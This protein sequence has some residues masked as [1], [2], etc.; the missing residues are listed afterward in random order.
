[1]RERVA[2]GVAER[3]A[4]ERH[5]HAAENEWTP[6][7]EA[8]C[9]E[10]VTDSHASFLDSRTACQGLSAGCAKSLR[11]ARRLRG[12][13]T[14]KLSLLEGT[15]MTS[16]PVRSSSAASSVASTPSRMR[17][18]RARRA[19]PRSCANCGVWA[20]QS[21]LRSSV[22]SYAPRRVDDFDRIDDRG[23]RAAPRGR[24][25]TS[26]IPARTSARRYQRARAVV[27]EHRV[28]L[29]GHGRQ[30]RAHAALPRRTAANDGEI[31]IRGEA[32]GERAHIARS[33]RVRWR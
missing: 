33:T 7:D 11:H 26:A 12:S 22:R 20:A 21:V 24:S 6:F 27:H 4:L 19:A 25:R 23:R 14:L 13:V 3:P 1:M 31:E 32:A 18:E 15:T 2:I 9:V 10:T 16:M 5:V 8:M 29:I 17:R 28:A 30:R